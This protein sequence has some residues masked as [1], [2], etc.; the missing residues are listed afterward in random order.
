MTEKD[1]HL[2]TSKTFFRFTLV[3][4]NSNGITGHEVDRIVKAGCSDALLHFSGWNVLFLDFIRAAETLG[5]AISPV[6]ENLKSAGFESI[7]R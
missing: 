6:M 5:D 7:C 1:F 4:K 3:L 2:L